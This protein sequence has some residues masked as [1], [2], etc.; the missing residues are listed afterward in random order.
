MNRARNLIGLAT[1][2]LPFIDSITEVSDASDGF[3]LIRAFAIYV[4]LPFGGA[5]VLAK[6]WKYLVAE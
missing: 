1:F 5:G 2:D 4:A 6:S 3:A